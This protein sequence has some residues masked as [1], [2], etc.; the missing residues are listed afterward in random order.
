MGAG[1]EWLLSAGLEAYL[2]RAGYD[3][4]CAHVEAPA[5][6]WRAGIRTAFELMRAL[7]T[8]VREARAAGRFP[9]VIAGNCNVAV[10]VLGGLG[11]RTGVLWFD[12]HGDFNTPETTTGGFL[13]GMALA[14][15]PGRCWPQ[16]TRSVPGFQLVPDQTTYLLGARDFDPLEAEALSRSAVRVFRPALI[17]SGLG[18]PLAELAERVEQVYVH[19]DLDVLDPSEGRVNEFAPADGM[20]RCEVEATLADIG[21]AVPIAAATL[22]AYDPRYDADGR[23]CASAFAL[24]D[25]LLAAVRRTASGA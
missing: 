3:V 11:P 22:S 15:V 7:A 1:P 2:S 23:V 4:A 17:R 9:L 8:R 24:I 13:D 19:P 21:R 14:T 16:L 12:A 5:D 25:A 20:R 18:S 6:S 10:G